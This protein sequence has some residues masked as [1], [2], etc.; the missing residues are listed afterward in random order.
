M[1][2]HA[3]AMSSNIPPRTQS[4]FGES[5]GTAASPD[6]LG[7]YSCIELTKTIPRAQYIKITAR[8]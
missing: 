1:H 8:N 3:K 4:T 6:L 7:A 2:C 5:K